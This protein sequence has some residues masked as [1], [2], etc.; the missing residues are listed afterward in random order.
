MLASLDCATLRT[1]APFAKAPPPQ[2][3]AVLCPLLQLLTFPSVLP[4][5]FHRKDSVG[6]S[7]A[8]R[9]AKGDPYTGRAPSLP[10]LLLS[11]VRR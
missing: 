4:L 5:V 1:P 7:L 8:A 11:T 2:V 10:Q 6:L 9:L 3:R